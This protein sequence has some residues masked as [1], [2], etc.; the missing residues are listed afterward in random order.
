MQ[1]TSNEAPVSMLPKSFPSS[2]SFFLARLYK[3]WSSNLS[4]WDF[5]LSVDIILL[6]IYQTNV[7][8]N[9]RTILKTRE[10]ISMDGT[11]MWKWRRFCVS[12]YGYDQI[13]SKRFG[14]NRFVRFQPICFEQIWSKFHFFE[15]KSD[16]NLIFWPLS[17]LEGCGWEFNFKTRRIGYNRLL[18]NRV[19]SYR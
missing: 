5:P 13:C 4:V 19:P 2:I 12:F 9:W 6:L 3:C 17:D 10:K 1:L 18:L 11:K 14:W 7:F 15:T 16:K 8:N